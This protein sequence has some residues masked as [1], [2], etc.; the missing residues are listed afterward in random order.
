MG[1]GGWVLQEGYMFKLSHLGQ[2]YRIKEKI[3]ELVGEE[4]TNQFYHEWVLNHT[5]KTDIDSMAAW[6]FNSIRLPMH[7]NLYTCR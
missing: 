6:G 2:Q 5:T 7:Y 1:I 3:K 4:K